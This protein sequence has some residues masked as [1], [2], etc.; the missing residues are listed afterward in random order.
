MSQKGF[1]PILIALGVILILGVVSG[2]YY[3]GKSQSVKPTIQNSVV[4]SQTPQ[5]TP[6]PTPDAIANWRTYTN[7][8]YKFTLSYPEDWESQVPEVSTNN[9]RLDFLKFDQDYNGFERPNITLIINNDNINNIRSSLFKEYNSKGTIQDI[10]LLSGDLY[11]GT[12]KSKDFSGKNTF[13]K[14]RAD[15]LISKN[16]LN[17]WFRL[18]TKPEYQN[19]HLE[20]FKKIIST[21][22]FTN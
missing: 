6:S 20:D 2:A 21:F 13:Q 15:Y 4:T 10:G 18:S 22:K 9:F 12:G 14:F 16:N 3:F 19:K 1:A 7:T 5:P 11:Q 17:Y 8:Q